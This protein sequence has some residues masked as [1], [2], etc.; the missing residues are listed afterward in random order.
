MFDT[1]IGYIKKLKKRYAGVFLIIG[2]LLF[3]LDQ[4]GRVQTI[5]A[6]YADIR[7][8]AESR[9]WLAG[10]TWPH[11]VLLYVGLLFVLLGLAAYLWPDRPASEQ[12]KPNE[13][14]AQPE[15]HDRTVACKEPSRVRH[16]GN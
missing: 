13:R 4:I 5:A 11:H 8:W 16:G 12:P 3:V 15:S 7:T 1:A 10:F 6:L 9:H 14:K 2:G